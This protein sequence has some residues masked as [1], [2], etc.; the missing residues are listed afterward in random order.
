MKLLVLTVVLT[1]VRANVFLGGAWLIGYYM[2]LL[3]GSTC[4][5]LGGLWWLLVL[6]NVQPFE[7]I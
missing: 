7:F 5:W 3:C 1:G 2:G 4:S 6:G